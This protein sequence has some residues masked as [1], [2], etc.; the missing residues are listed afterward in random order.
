MSRWRPERAGG[1]T[2]LGCDARR[3]AGPATGVDAPDSGW[4]AAALQQA[5]DTLAAGA[6]LQ[7]RIA[8]DLCRHFVIEAAAGLRS[9]AELRELAALRAVQLFGG[10]AEGWAVVADWR[11]DGPFACAALPRPLLQAWQQ[12]AGQRRLGVVSALLLAVQGLLAGP[13][14]SGFVGF[15]TPRHAV[16]LGLRGGRL[17]SLHA[18]R[19]AEAD[20]TKTLSDQLARGAAREALLGGQD[21]DT[22]VALAWA[23]PGP[24]PAGA[25]DAADRLPA[26]RADDTEAAWAQRLGSVS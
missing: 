4:D 11:L 6:S 2:V 10:A 13:A 14:R 20:D 16:L 8:P 3:L 5:L 18:T 22:P 21:V 9:L 7:V 25:W 19:R 24:L 15:A 12:A 23:G 1:V 17:L 26:L